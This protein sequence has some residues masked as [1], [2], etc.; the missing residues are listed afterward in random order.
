LNLGVF[1]VVFGVEIADDVRRGRM[2]VQKQA[3]DRCGAHKVDSV[4]LQAMQS[5]SREQHEV[6][7]ALYTGRAMHPGQPNSTIIIDR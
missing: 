5:S 4:R 6:R 1:C 3:L 7:C 2:G